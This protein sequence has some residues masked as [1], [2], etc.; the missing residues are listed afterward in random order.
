MLEKRSISSNKTSDSQS[1]KTDN[2]LRQSIS[3]FTKKLLS[4]I[5]CC[6]SPRDESQPHEQ[7]STSR[8]SES[9]DQRTETEKV[10][11][12]KELLGLL[13]AISTKID[14]KSEGDGQKPSS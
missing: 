1:R 8:V 12:V 14:D 10:G 5:T 13:N 2:D 6:V 11:G 3:R 4:H 7:D 9:G